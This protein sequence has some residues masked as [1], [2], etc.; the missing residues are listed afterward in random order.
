MF[1]NLKHCVSG[2]NL[3]FSGHPDLLL[4]HSPSNAVLQGHPL[5]EAQIPSSSGALVAVHE[6]Q[7]VASQDSKPYRRLLRVPFPETLLQGARDLER[8]VD[9]HA[10]GDKNALVSQA[11]GERDLLQQSAAITARSY[12]G[13]A[14]VRNLSHQR[15]DSQSQSNRGLHVLHS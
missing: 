10:P 14:Q 11:R 7:A 12:R 8:P 3:S 2:D 15:S 13:L 5:I 9:A 1:H 6:P 4:P